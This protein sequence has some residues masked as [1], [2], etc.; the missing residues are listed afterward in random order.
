MARAEGEG[1]PRRSRQHDDL[2]PVLR[3]AQ[4]RDGP[5]VGPGPGQDAGLPRQRT[6]P[7]L[8]QEDLRELGLGEDPQPPP[9]ARR[10]REQQEKRQ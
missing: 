9:E 5:G 4:A 1:T 10:A 6:F 2:H 8:F 7:G 3:G